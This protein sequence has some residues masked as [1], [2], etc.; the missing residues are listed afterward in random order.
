[1][2]E[3]GSWVP[4][5]A[6]GWGSGITRKS[7]I[8]SQ[9]QY[10]ARDTLYNER[11]KAGPKRT[12]TLSLGDSSRPV[13]PH[14]LFGS[15]S[16]AVCTSCNASE[17]IRPLRRCAKCHSAAYCSTECQASD[18]KIHKAFCKAQIG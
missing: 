12:H 10:W 7:A 6:I 5:S 17:S 14:T 15:K 13:D 9:G 18:W 3:C 1:M 8:V 2:P 4:L 11:W 16:D